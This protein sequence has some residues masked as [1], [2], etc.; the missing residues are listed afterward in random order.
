MQ[1]YSHGVQW[2]FREDRNAHDITIAARQQD[3][4]C[5]RKRKLIRTWLGQPL[6]SAW[7][8][9]T[10]VSLSGHIW[11]DRNLS[12]LNPWAGSVRSNTRRS[13]RSRVCRWGTIN[14]CQRPRWNFR[15]S[16]VQINSQDTVTLP[17]SFN[18]GVLLMPPQHSI[19]T[20]SDLRQVG[21]E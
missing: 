9:Q 13:W 15:N 16:F 3:Q 19:L 4:G 1:E 11:L 8:D 10:Q 18:T 2:A 14:I 20:S 21:N 5:V 17:P 6:N 12:E 7:A